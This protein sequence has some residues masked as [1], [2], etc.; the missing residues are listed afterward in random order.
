MDKYNQGVIYTNDKC[1]GCN[2]CLGSCSLMG[3]NVSVVTNGSAQMKIDSR[4]CNDC[5]KCISVCVHEARS[6]RDDTD[7]FF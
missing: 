1:I 3:A 2:K 7:A 5:G 4:K 6:Y